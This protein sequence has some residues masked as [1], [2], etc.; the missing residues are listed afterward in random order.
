MD[1]SPYRI[2]FLKTG[3][4]DT[5]C[6]SYILGFSRRQFID[7]TPRR[8]FFTLIRRHTDAFTC[9]G[10]VPAQCL[11]DSEKTVVLRWEAEARS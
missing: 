4:A 10:G 6:F 1:W 9:F 11:Y 2:K 8:D 5:Q 7:F 3:P